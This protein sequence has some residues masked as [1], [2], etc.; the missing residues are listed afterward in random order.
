MCIS[1]QGQVRFEP[2]GTFDNYNIGVGAGFTTMYGDLQQ[3]GHLPVYM[4]NVSR[5][6]I[7]IITLAL[8]IQHGAFTSSTPANAWT[9]G[10]SETNHFT[11]VGLNGNLSL[12][13]I[14]PYP[15]NAFTKA[16]SSFYVGTGIGVIDNNLTNIT[17]KF[18]PTDPQTISFDIEKSSITEVVPF[19]LGFNINL[20][21][22]LVEGTR[23]NVN[24]ELAYAFNDYVDGYSFISNSPKKEYNDI[25]SIL[26]VGLSFPLGGFKY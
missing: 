2:S 7:P 22:F 5:P 4:I 14:I 23:L 3:S 19:N 11:T 18:R 17:D 10:L 1:A 16:L 21:K 12:S 25:Y 8:E 24:Y 20:K 13:S 15:Q 6:L 9:S 26:S